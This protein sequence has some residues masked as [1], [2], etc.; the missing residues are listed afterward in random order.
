MKHNICLLIL[1]VT[2]LLYFKLLACYI[3][4]C[5]KL[6]CYKYSNEYCFFSFF[7]SFLLLL[8]TFNTWAIVANAISVIASATFYLLCLHYKMIDHN[9]KYDICSHTP[10]GDSLLYFKLLARCKF[11][12]IKLLC[13]KVENNICKIATFCHMAFLSFCLNRLILIKH[14]QY[15][16][17]Y[18]LFGVN[19]MKRYE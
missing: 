3:F 18:Q 17:R 13:Y 7:Y 4:Y 6:L 5:K 8:S 11:Y 19:E 9:M 15:L 16:S 1:G 2:S 12:Y 10:E 14:R